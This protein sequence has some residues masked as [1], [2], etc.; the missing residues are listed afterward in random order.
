MFVF[1]RKNPPRGGV[2]IDDSSGSKKRKAPPKGRGKRKETDPIEEDDDEP[3]NVPN[4]FTDK[5]QEERYG[6]LKKWNFIAEKRVELKAGECD[7]F[8]DNLAYRHW[9][10]LSTLPDKFDPIIVREFYANAFHCKKDNTGNYDQRFSMVRGVKVKYD[11]N[12]INV[13]LNRPFPIDDV[14]YYHPNRGL[15]NAEDVEEVVQAICFQGF[16]L[17]QSKGEGRVVPRAHLTRLGKLWAAYLI[18]N[19]KPNGH[20]NTYKPEDCFWI[21]C[22]MDREKSINVARAISES[23]VENVFKKGAKQLLGHPSLITSICAV[24]GIPVNRCKPIKNPFNTAYLRDY[25]SPNPPNAPPQ[26][27]NP[28]GP[29]RNTQELHGY[30]AQQFNFLNLQNAATNRKLDTLYQSHAEYS[31]SGTPFPPFATFQSIGN[32]PGDVPHFPE[33]VGGVGGQ[34]GGDHG[35]AEPE[36][37]GEVNAEPDEEYDPLHL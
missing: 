6:V 11:P 12:A 28:V 16:G 1:H 8:T 23:L 19:I 5:D 33:G 37:G 21:Y 17:V 10:L 29:S 15:L 13:F 31:L 30:L 34:G 32:W 14:D 35:D 36:G 26:P 2:H 20:S 27:R 3:M 4:R 25:V 7:E 24:Q 22:L 18:S 9:N